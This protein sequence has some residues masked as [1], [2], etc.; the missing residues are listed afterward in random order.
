MLQV[1]EEA[2]LVVTYC[3]ALAAMVFALRAFMYIFELM[4]EDRES[5]EDRKTKE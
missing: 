4:D 2:M 3:F 5:R 1:L